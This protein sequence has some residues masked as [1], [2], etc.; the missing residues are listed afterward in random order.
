VDLSTD[1]RRSLRVGAAVMGGL[2]AAIVAVLV[3]SGRTLTPG[4]TL[5]V[6]FARTGPLIEGSPVRLAGRDIGQVQAISFAGD[7]LGE[8]GSGAQGQPMVRATLYVYDRY[9]GF[10]H[11]NSDYFINRIGVIG[12]PFLEVGPPRNAEPGPLV[13][14][15]DIV[16]GADPPDLDHLLA[17]MHEN[18]GVINKLFQDQ[19]PKAV[20]LAGDFRSLVADAESIPA[21][22]GSFS[23]ITT[24]A[25]SVASDVSALRAALD[26]G[27]PL[28]RARAVTTESLDTLHLAQT[29]TAALQT[30]VTKV[31]ADVQN[32]ISVLSPTNRARLTAALAKLGVSLA[33][34]QTTYADAQVIAGQIQRGEG[35]LGAFLFDNELRDDMVS[36]ARILK[37]R[38][39]AT[40]SPT[41]TPQQQ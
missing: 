6:D 23:R 39:W 26:R 24:G 22:A 5:Y 15:G 1:E 16:R 33:R 18:L 35:T 12:E 14:A 21:P 41:D 29:R 38:P 17:Y 36:I 37:D 4:F 40:L 7:S 34:A 19:G 28:R 32:A 10:L 20:A 2:I 31:Q 3:L 9:Q 30:E 11:D 13:T 8:N 27:D 25:R